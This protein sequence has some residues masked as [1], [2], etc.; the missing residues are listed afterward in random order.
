MTTPRTATERRLPS[1]TAVSLGDS[2][3]SGEAGRWNGNSVTPAGDKDGTDRAC[4]PTG[5]TCQVDK[6]RVYEPSTE[7]AACHRSDVA[8]IKSSSLPVAERIDLSCSG[9]KT[10]NIFRASQG[11]WARTANR[12]RPISCCSLP[13]PCTA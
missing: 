10:D 7:D 2:Y 11:V 5:P 1:C 6:T 8:E 13:R 9:G 3:I 12:P 4:Q